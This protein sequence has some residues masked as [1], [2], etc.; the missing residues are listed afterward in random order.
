MQSYSAEQLTVTLTF[1]LCRQKQFQY[2]MC[3]NIG[4]SGCKET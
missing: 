3:T 1:D 4:R 2:Y